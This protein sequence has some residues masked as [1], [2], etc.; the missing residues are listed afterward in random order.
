MALEPPAMTKTPTV[1]SSPRTVRTTRA[2]HFLC[3]SRGLVPLLFTS[4]APLV[5][6][7][8]PSQFLPCFHFTSIALPIPQLPSRLQSSLFSAH[9]MLVILMDASFVTNAVFCDGGEASSASTVST[10][11]RGPC[12]TDLGRIIYYRILL[13]LIV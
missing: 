13:S 11:I 12:Q 6:F 5:Y 7:L 1:F 4:C 2:S 10:A 8:F 9:R 3:P